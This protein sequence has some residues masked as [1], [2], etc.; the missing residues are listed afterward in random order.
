MSELD[1]LIC[2]RWCNGQHA[3]IHMGAMIGHWDMHRTSSTMHGRTNWTTLLAKCYYQVSVWMETLRRITSA[4][5]PWKDYFNLEIVKLAPPQNYQNHLGSV[6]GICSSLGSLEWY[7]MA[8]PHPWV[9]VWLD[10]WEQSSPILSLSPCLIQFPLSPDPSLPNQW[11]TWSGSFSKN[12]L[13][14]LCMERLCMMELVRL[15]WDYF[16]W[17]L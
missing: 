14:P 15:R 4:N 9:L 3:Q 13:G 8:I 2:W 12:S 16:G 5:G 17:R 7:W 6:L 1:F 11:Y 10:R